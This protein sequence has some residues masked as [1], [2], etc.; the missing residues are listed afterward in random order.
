MPQAILPLFEE[1]I[2]EVNN[3]IG[4]KKIGDAVY[5]FQGHLPV[6]R[7]LARDEKAFRSFCCQLINLGNATSADIARA[8][9]VNRE[10]LSRWARIDRTSNLIEKNIK[11]N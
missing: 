9:K 11:K 3:Y 2:I 6:Y 10:K 4:V 8:L 7:H 1:E 5:W